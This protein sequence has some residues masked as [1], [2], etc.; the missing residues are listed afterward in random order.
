MG[1]TYL[2]ELLVLEKKMEKR[3]KYTT[4]NGS[5]KK[6]VRRLE[7]EWK[8]KIKILKEENQVF[9]EEFSFSN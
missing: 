2:L 3:R 5:E 7:E 4:F 9:K 8:K 1:K 6:L